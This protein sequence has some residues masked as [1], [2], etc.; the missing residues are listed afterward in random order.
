[1]YYA[2]TKLMYDG[3]SAAADDASCVAQLFMRKENN[4][5]STRSLFASKEPLNPLSIFDTAY[6]NSMKILMVSPL[7]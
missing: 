4:L 7:R 5:S 6:N 3:M 1:M 2:K